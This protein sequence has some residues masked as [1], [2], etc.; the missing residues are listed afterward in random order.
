MEWKSNMCSV[1]VEISNGNSIA[2]KVGE[3]DEWDSNVLGSIP[4]KSYTVQV[5]RSGTAMIGMARLQGFKLDGTNHMPGEAGMYLSLSSGNLYP[6]GKR[7]HDRPI[8]ED[9][10][11]QVIYDTKSR[12]ISFVIDS[13]HKGVAFVDIGTEDMYPSIAFYSKDTCVQLLG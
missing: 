12:T 9:S 5:I 7:Y 11:I 3:H 8:K 1:G 6:T 10:I 4:N 13:V 2:I